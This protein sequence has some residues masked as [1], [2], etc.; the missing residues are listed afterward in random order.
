MTRA[1]PLALV[2]ALAGVGGVACGSQPTSCPP[3]VGVA[4][5]RR[6]A[7]VFE[8]IV[9]DHWNET[10]ID[11]D[12]WRT[13]RQYRFQVQRNWT[14]GAVGND[15]HLTQ[16]WYQGQ[17]YMRGTYPVFER[18]HRYLVFVVAHDAPAHAFTTSCQPGAEGDHIARLAAQLGPPAE[19]FEEAPQLDPPFWQPAERAAEDSTRAIMQVIHHAVRLSTALMR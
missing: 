7:G 3:P 8:G 17:P 11:G 9:V 1:R 16:G 15:R 6:Y 19:T 4:D 5:V 13:L 14:K 10:L 18:G 2:T 12:G